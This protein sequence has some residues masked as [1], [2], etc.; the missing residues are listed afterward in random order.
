MSGCSQ[1]TVLRTYLDALLRH[2]EAPGEAEALEVLA[3]AMGAQ[4]TGRSQPAPSCSSARSPLPASAAVCRAPRSMTYLLRRSTRCRREARQPSNELEKPR[5]TRRS[6]ELARDGFS[7]A[8]AS[9]APRRGSS[10][11]RIY[12]RDSQS[13]PWR[14]IIS[15]PGSHGRPERWRRCIDFGRMLTRARARQRGD[16]RRGLD[17]ARQEAFGHRSSEWRAGLGVTPFHPERAEPYIWKRC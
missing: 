10:P 7:E 14:A 17:L 4:S 1:P 6:H 16:R 3:Q 12:R 13:A 5:S 2:G 15:A 8:G 11:T 9:P